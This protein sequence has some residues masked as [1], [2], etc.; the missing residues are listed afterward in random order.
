MSET[1]DP[2]FLEECEREALHRI[3][4][5]QP[6][7][8]LLGGSAGDGT[9]RFASADLDDW[10]GQPAANVLGQPLEVLLKALAVD[11]AEA[12]ALAVAAM[13]PQPA[14]AIQAEKRL[15]PGLVRGRRGEM[16]ALLCCS[17]DTWLMELQPA[18]TPELRHQAY[19]PVPHGLYRMPQSPDEWQ[20]QCRFLAE[21][22]RAGSGFERVMV[23]RFRDDGS[24]EV[25]AESAAEG[26][27]PYLGL[28]YPAAD[29]PQIARNL[30]LAN[31]HRQIP[32]VASE[33]VAI[34]CANEQAPDLTLSDLRAVSPVHI[35]YLKNM[36][37]TASLSFP[38]VLN[39]RLWGLIACHHRRPRALPLPVRERCAEMVQVFALGLS[40]YQTSRRLKALTTTD[41][42]IERLI[43]GIRGL[44]SGSE[45]S[46]RL[47]EAL[48]ELVGAGG[49]ALLEEGVPGML[50]F[51]RT[52]DPDAIHAQLSWLRS[53]QAEPIFATDALSTLLPAAAASKDRASGLLA[54]RV[55][56]F[57]DGERR[58]RTFLW[59]RPEQPQTVSW[60][61]DPR[62]SALFDAQSR[63]LSPRSSFETWV[64]TMSGHSEPWSET[65]LLM[66]KKFRGLILRVINADLLRG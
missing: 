23:Y 25:I 40:G 12:L 51:G 35:Q 34:L 55:G 9:V 63:T 18:L 39:R 24:G 42:D 2:G 33:P 49:A 54:V 20:Q 10:V 61:G 38:V 41:R 13:A 36:G 27:A 8:A 28:R 11:Q 60:A 21:Q 50:L 1:L 14:P 58:E 16:D 59:W 64:E 65:D 57:V 32:D 6:Y 43:H 46:Y 7:G 22:M 31:R 37:V 17:E 30:Y 62:K 45:P 48:L 4:A 26:L 19:Q 66:A 44:E 52:P 15:L 3:G 53:T 47:G 5:V 29:I 56:L